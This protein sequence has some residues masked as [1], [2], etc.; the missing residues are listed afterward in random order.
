MTVLMTGGTGFLGRALV[1]RALS[2]HDRPIRLLVRDPGKLVDP[3]TSRLDVVRGDMR[4]EASLE[5]AVQGIDLVF[6]L[7][8]TRGCSWDEHYQAT[9]QGTGRLLRAAARAGVRR[10][11]YVSSLNVVD[12]FGSQEII[13]ETCPLRT[14]YLND[15]IRS[16][17][18][19]EEAVRCEA[20]TGELQVLVARPG[21]LFGPGAPVPLEVG[22][23][24]GRDLVV[25]PAGECAMPTVYADHAASA[26]LLIADRGAG[27]E[28]YHV[29]DDE[30]VSKL[31]Y[32]QLLR[33]H[34]N[35]KLRVLRMP[36]AA[37]SAVRLG[38][39]CLRR[40]HPAFR[41]A[42]RRT[43]ILVD[44]LKRGPE[45]RYSNARLKQ[46]GWQQPA[47]TDV[48]VTETVRTYGRHEGHAQL[49]QHAA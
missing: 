3:D 16:K 17:M 10:F 21:Q 42:H 24:L 32:L 2:R 45:L 13:D 20:E 39:M 5:A 30:P 35:P 8:T 4:D 7:A 29:L 46:L 1:R 36:Y 6:H 43:S 37:I 31:R 41:H 28:V 18:L 38:A 15:Y 40:V 25:I 34:Y 33:E 14:R 12:I 22:Y 48:T 23:P 44:R 9:V 11:V 19:A 27:G 26:L 47:P 49:V